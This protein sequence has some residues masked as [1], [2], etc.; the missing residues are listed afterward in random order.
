M[1]LKSNAPDQGQLESEGN[2]QQSMI[3]NYSLTMATVLKRE[4]GKADKMSSSSTINENVISNLYSKKNP[5][6]GD[7]DQ[8]QSPSER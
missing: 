8:A 3:T 6:T 7:L 2:L 1:E 5:P 4:S